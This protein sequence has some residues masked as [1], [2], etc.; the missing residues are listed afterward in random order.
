LKE[1][2][3]N[4]TV[5]HSPIGFKNAKARDK[6]INYLKSIMAEVPD[7]ECQELKEIVD[8]DYGLL[9]L[10]TNAGRDAKKRT[11]TLFIVHS[12]CNSEGRLGIDR[13]R[14]MAKMTPQQLK[15]FSTKW[16]WAREVHQEAGEVIE[17]WHTVIGDLVT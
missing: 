4:L 14:L 6:Y 11:G 10:A 17:E 8:E 5:Y 2:E 15:L 7:K 16:E 12:I 13:M 3:N 1:R 9:E